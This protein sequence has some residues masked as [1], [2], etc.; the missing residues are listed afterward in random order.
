[1]YKYNSENEKFEQYGT[2]YG[3]GGLCDGSHFP[4]IYI[5]LT[6]N[7]VLEFLKS[8][9]TKRGKLIYRK[10]RHICNLLKKRHLP[11]APWNFQ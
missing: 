4:G 10:G 2:I 9:G 5:K 3:S 11:F 7:R 1:M 6:N 8:N